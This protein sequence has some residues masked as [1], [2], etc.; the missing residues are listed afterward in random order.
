MMVMPTMFCLKFKDLLKYEA[1]FAQYTNSTWCIFGLSIGLILVSFGKDSSTTQTSLY[2]ANL[3]G[4]LFIDLL[5]MVLIPLVFT[6]ITVGVANLQ[7][8]QQI[9]RVWISTLSFSH[10]QCLLR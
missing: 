3:I 7:A 2:V 4:T 8:H 9:H 6:S 1:P 10:F 5:K